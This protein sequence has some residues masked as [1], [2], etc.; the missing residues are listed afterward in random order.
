MKPQH[1]LN[2]TNPHTVT[3]ADTHVQKLKYQYGDSHAQ[4]GTPLQVTV[5]H[6]L[7]LA[8]LAFIQP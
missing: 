6:P 8:S 5:L 3:F 7:A 2:V 1:Q 4:A